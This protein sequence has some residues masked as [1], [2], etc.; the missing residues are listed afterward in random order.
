MTTKKETKE[1][2]TKCCDNVW[3]YICI[4]LGI[5]FIIALVFAIIGATKTANDNG[6]GT[7]NAAKII[8]D[9]LKKQGID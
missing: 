9:L 3:M 2:S 8:T 5:A 6:I 1:Q 7:D 4:G